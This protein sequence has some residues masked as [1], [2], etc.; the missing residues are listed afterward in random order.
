MT[1][2]LNSLEIGIVSRRCKYSKLSYMTFKRGNHGHIRGYLFVRLLSSQKSLSMTVLSVLRSVFKPYMYS[3]HTLKST[4]QYQINGDKCCKI[5]LFYFESAITEWQT[6][7]DNVVCNFVWIWAK[8]LSGGFLTP[9]I[10]SG[11]NYIETDVLNIYS[12]EKKNIR[13]D[14]VHNFSLMKMKRRN[15]HRFHDEW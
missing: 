9:Q 4:K 11:Q 6:E 12:S 7:T 8:S 15:N 5:P 2:E 14:R 10:T 1:L 13:I 3:H